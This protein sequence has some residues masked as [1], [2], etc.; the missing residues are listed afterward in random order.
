MGGYELSDGAALG[1]GLALLS[2]IRIEI[3]L[4]LTLG[5]FRCLIG[6]FERDSLR[7]DKLLLTV[8]V[9][10]QVLVH[11][12]RRLLLA[13]LQCLFCRVYLITVLALIAWTV[14]VTLSEAWLGDRRQHRPSISIGHVL[15]IGRIF[16]LLVQG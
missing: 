13:W 2:I 6:A 1:S 3:F 7:I 5:R 10:S 16:E 12:Q 8:V 4:T 11:G 15:T 14:V 9:Q